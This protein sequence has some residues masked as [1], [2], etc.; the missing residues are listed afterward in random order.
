MKLKLL[1]AFLIIYSVGVSAQKDSLPA[2][3]WASAYGGITQLQI[4]DG[5]VDKEGN[6]ISTGYFSGTMDL[7]QDSGYSPLT[8]VPNVFGN[9]FIQKT[10]SL[11]DFVWG[12]GIIDSCTL[13][14]PLTVVTDKDNS[15][16]VGGYYYGCDSLDVDPDPSTAFYLKADSLTIRMFLIKL[17]ENGM[18]QWGL[19]QKG[20]SCKRVVL[21]EL[22]NI[23]LIGI[24]TGDFDSNPDPAITDIISSANAND[25]DFFVEKLDPNGNQ[26]WIRVLQGPGF[27]DVNSLTLNDNGD[28]VVAG[29]I[30]NTVDFNQGSSPSLSV[31]PEASYNGYVFRMDSLGNSKDVF[32]LQ[33]TSPSRIIDL[34]TD[35]H[36][37]LY[38]VGWYN[39]TD[40]DFDPGSGNWPLVANATGGYFIMK[41]SESG[42]PEWVRPYDNPLSSMGFR[43]ID[44][45]L[46]KRNVTYVSGRL[47]R[48]SVYLEPD[49]PNG[50]VLQHNSSFQ[51]MFQAAYDSTGI[52]SWA[53]VYEGDNNAGTCRVIAMED[54]LYTLGYFTNHISLGTT[55]PYT[56]Q[57]QPGNCLILKQELPKNCYHK[58]TTIS[59]YACD[60]LVGPNGITYHSSVQYT[61]SLFTSDLCD[62]LVTHR[63]FIDSPPGTTV[64]MD[65][66]F[67]RLRVPAGAE[68]YQW[69]NC[70]ADT[71][72]PRATDYFFDVQVPGN[73]AVIVTNGECTDT[74]ACV[75]SLGIGLAEN[76]AR[77]MISIYPNPTDGKLQVG[78]DKKEIQYIQ[79]YDFSGRL[80]QKLTSTNKL[81]I[82][83]FPSGIYMVS[84]KTI[85]GV[86]TTWIIKE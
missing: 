70:D 54:Y 8:A 76:V 37:N 41:A 1:L 26:L 5:A 57:G 22:G 29:H 28:V 51:A 48:K 74:S 81:D 68:S 9:G 61:D 16:L 35:D 83:S 32:V 2:L 67:N 80:L 3:E 43:E 55:A 82:S 77:E 62:S 7:E 14:S 79:I 4:W 40:V 15:I 33:G 58:D 18:F 12:K 47:I 45:S 50:T 59:Y 21:D 10:D 56:L 19:E 84:I 65:T 38:M 42:A 31:T 52:L 53:H 72:I 66:I 13:V 30:A 63:I 6:L 75:A 60:S 17:D 73:Y 20:G 34:E 64:V 11:G 69:I 25:R 49:N 44:L 71:L 46:G 24:F 85:Q 78:R 27:T 36:N 39:G 23:Y 86:A